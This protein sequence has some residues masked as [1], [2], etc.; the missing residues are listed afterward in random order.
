M[1]FYSKL[2]SSPQPYN[3]LGRQ[4]PLI[5]PQLSPVSSDSNLSYNS[6][7]TNNKS[8]ASAT[9]KRQKFFRRIFKFR[10]M[11]FEYAF[12]Q[13]LYLFVSPQKVLVSNLL[14][15]YNLVIFA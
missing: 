4:A 2:T 8:R 3:G 15:L 7:M 12:W 9:A 1:E 13:M 10:Q 14:L 5:T 11:D 6:S